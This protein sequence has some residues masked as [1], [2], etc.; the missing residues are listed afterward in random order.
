[1]FVT[2]Q[3]NE[4]VLVFTPDGTVLDEWAVG[5]IPSGIAVSQSNTVYVVD[6]VAKK[7]E[8]YSETGTHLLTIGEGILTEATEVAVG[9]DGDI[10]ATDQGARGLRRF[11]PSGAY[12]GDVGAGLVAEPLGVAFDTDGSCFITDATNDCVWKFGSD[13]AFLTRWGSPGQGPGQ[14][15]GPAGI[16]VDRN[17]FVFVA[18]HVN[19][20]VEGFSNTGTFLAAWSSW[21]AASNVDTFGTP[22]DVATDESGELYV[23]DGPNSRVVVFGELPVPTR[24]AS[25][26][27]LKLSFR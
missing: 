15:A 21:G 17:H 27:A 24:H 9:P 19:G 25:W 20:R 13:G 4:R 3:T 11:D 18:D 16:C 8:A 5:F 22:L 23:T 12:L 10:Y 2:D 1:V 6:F 26:G 14:F 7:V